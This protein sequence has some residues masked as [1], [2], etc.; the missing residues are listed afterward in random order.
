MMDQAGIL[1]KFIQGVKAMTERDDDRGEDNFGSDF[2]RLRRLSTKYRTEKIYPTDI[3]ER[4]ENVKKNRYKDILPFDHTRVKL[5]LKTTNQD[6]DYINANFIKGMDGPE[7]YIA[8]QGALPNTVVDFWRMNWEYNVAV[9]VM[10]CREFEMGRKKCERY[11][12][13]FGEPVSFGPFRISCES[14]QARTDYSIRTLVVEYENETRRITQ[15]HYINWPDHDVPSSF[16]SILDMIGLMREYQENDDVPICVHCSAG[17]G[18]TGAICAI[19]YT[20]NLLKAGK[21]PENFNVFQLIQ[22]MRTQRHSAVQTKEQY[23]LV[24]RAIA[25]L[26]QKQLQLLE[27]P[28]NVQIHDVTNESSPDKVSHQSDDERWDSPPPKP[29]RIRSTQVEGDVKEE[30]LQPPEPHPVPPILTPSPPSAFPTVTNVR[31]DNDRYH[32]KPVIHVLATAQQNVTQN[33]GAAKEKNLAE[34]GP[35]TQTGTSEP[36]DQNLLCQKQQMSNLDLNENYNNK[37]SAATAKSESGP[38]LTPSLPVSPAAECCGAPRIERKLSIEIKKVPL[39]GGP[40]SFDTSSSTGAASGAGGGSANSAGTLQRC[41]AFKAPS[42]QSVLTSSSSLS[43]DSGT[44]GGA[45]GC[46]E[47]QGDGGVLAR[48]NHLPVKSD[49]GERAELKASHVAWTQPCGSPE[50]P[51]PK[52]SS[53]SSSSD[54]IAPSS[55]SSSHLSSTSSSSS[56]PVRTALSFTNPLHSDNSDEDGDGE[57]SAGREGYRTSVSTATVTSLHFGDHQPVRKVSPVSIAGQSSSS[58]AAVTAN[59]WDSD[60]SP[61]PLPERTPESFIL[62]TDP[63]EVRTPASAERSGSHKD[64]SECVKKTSPADR[65]CSGTTATNS[66]ADLGGVR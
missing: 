26:F 18:R 2:M 46:G 37:L 60:D 13:L 65:Q 15:F 3:G 41:H 39:Q 42:G 16:D 57:M 40:R 45:G 14:E 55:S 19:D 44:E 32:P 27:S 4:E 48:P 49:G 63:L 36:K 54:R 10:A 34:A 47:S 66:K 17:C 50:K 25:Q 52:T 28:T 6:T 7:A 35:K 43:E 58:P 61:P 53:S 56:T 33:E 62:A 11:F 12:P 29:P 64:L 38:S 30:I 5:T 51:F 9:I 20:W 21:I 23:E 59:S 24:H 22:E 8:T 31:Q 1:R